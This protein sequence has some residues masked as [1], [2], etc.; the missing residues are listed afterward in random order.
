MS[1]CISFH[2]RPSVGYGVNI[3]VTLSPS[4][5]PARRGGRRCD[6]FRGVVDIFVHARV[7]PRRADRARD[8]RT[9]GTALERRTPRSGRTRFVSFSRFSSVRETLCSPLINGFSGRKSRNGF[10]SGTKTRPPHVFYQQSMW[11]YWILFRNR[12]RS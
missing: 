1:H 8:N 7:G 2:A 6:I 9:S 5:G 10:V 3:P 12:S 4:G 11:F